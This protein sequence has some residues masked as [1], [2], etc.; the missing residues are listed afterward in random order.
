MKPKT[1]TKVRISDELYN[2]ISDN[3]YIKE[4]H[5]TASGD[6]FFNVHELQENKRGTGKFYG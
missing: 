5:F 6:H 1:I 3:D 2:L 4:V